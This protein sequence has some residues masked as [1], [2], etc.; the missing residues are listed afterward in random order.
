MNI[1][2]EE[3]IFDHLQRVR[4]LAEEAAEDDGEETY[5]SRASAMSAL[6]AILRDLVKS[7][8]KVYNMARLQAVEQVTVETVKKFV[9]EQYHEEFLSE[10][11][12][13]VSRVLH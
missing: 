5:S 11:S 1:D 9:P 13:A 6:S 7:Q 3:E 8:E 10:L 12:R 4:A 2:L